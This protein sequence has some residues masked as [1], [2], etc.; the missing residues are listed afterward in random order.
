[1]EE[2]VSPGVND[3]ISGEGYQEDNEGDFDS[4]RLIDKL[5]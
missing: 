3:G 4:A 1:V 2:K 5:S